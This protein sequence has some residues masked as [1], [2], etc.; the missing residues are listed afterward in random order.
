MPIANKC[1]NAILAKEPLSYF[2]DGIKTFYDNIKSLSF[3]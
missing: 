3:F 2:N 1:I